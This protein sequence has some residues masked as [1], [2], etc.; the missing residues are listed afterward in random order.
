MLDVIISC[1][2]CCFVLFFLL[3]PFIYFIYLFVYYRRLYDSILMA[4]LIYH[5]PSYKAFFFL[6]QKKTKNK[7]HDSF[8]V[9]LGDTFFII[10]TL[11]CCR[12]VIFFRKYRFISHSFHSKFFAQYSSSM[13]AS[14]SIFCS[15]NFIVIGIFITK[16]TSRINSSA[17]N[18]WIHDSF[19]IYS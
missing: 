1:L 17:C 14:W 2:L 7:K 16:G 11:L 4:M 6:K 9:H 18:D 15:L 10:I 8:V 12:W 13:I 5:F 3:M 19:C